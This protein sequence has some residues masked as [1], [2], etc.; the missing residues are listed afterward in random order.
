MA[1]QE[2]TGDLIK[3]ANQGQFNVITHGCN[4]FCVMGAGI[5]PQM[6]KA[7]GCDG[8]PLE[9]S[10][11]RGNISK[12]GQIEYHK[13][14]VNEDKDDLWVV[15]SYTQYGLGTNHNDGTKQ[16][17]DYEALTLCLRKINKIFKGLKVGLPQI[18]AGLAGGDWNV[19]KQI[20]ETELK[21]CETTVVIYDKNVIKK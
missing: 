16:P 8:F 14:K 5:A 4:C 2:I 19:I 21:D 11:F 17:L 13:V 15:N 7:Y 12:L 6:A 9:A 20:I 1:Y 18:G 3:L 10:H